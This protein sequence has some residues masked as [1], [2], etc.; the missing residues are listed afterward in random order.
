MI[1]LNFEEQTI[2]VRNRFDEITMK[3]FDS[4]ISMISN[5]PGVR[6]LVK[7][8]EGL[9]D[10]EIDFRKLSLGTYM[11][12]LDNFLVDDITEHTPSFKYDKYS[13]KT[14]KGELTLT[15]KQVSQLEKVYKGEIE[16]KSSMVISILFA[17]EYNED[18]FKLIRQE[19]ASEFIGLL[20][21]VKPI[22]INIV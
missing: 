10:K 19:K 11:Q 14:K 9:C 6:P 5:N 7:I 22:E 12:L 8:I 13:I 3:E 16:D 1:N 2:K 15:G 4:F 21:L 18:L 20:N 17:G